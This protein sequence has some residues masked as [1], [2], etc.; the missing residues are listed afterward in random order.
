MTSDAF[1][2]GA[3][4][5]DPSQFVEIFE[6]HYEAIARY[7]RRRLNAPAATDLAA[8]V[9]TTAF[10][11][12]ASY[13]HA[14]PDA[15]PWLYG[16]ATNLLRAHVRSEERQLALIA[17]AASGAATASTDTADQ[18]VDR[19]LQQ[20]LAQ[21]LLDLSLED[22]EVLLLF[23]WAD[24]GYEEIASALDLPLGTVKSRLNRARQRLRAIL[25]ETHLDPEEA[26]RG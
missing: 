1:Q 5:A 26:S 6:R 25:C 16:I 21:A 14:Y 24:L 15:L 19:V 12:R 18:V 20:S 2:V 9:F 8:D 4:L 7:V 23:A 11:R 13:D 17:R 10:A 3:S 22:R